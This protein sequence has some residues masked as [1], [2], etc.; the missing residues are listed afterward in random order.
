MTRIQSRN[1]STNVSGSTSIVTILM[2]LDCAL[3]GISWS[4]WWLANTDADLFLAQLYSSTVAAVD[5]TTNDLPNLIGEVRGAMKVGAAFGNQLESIGFFQP[6]FG[7][8]IARN[9]RLNLAL[10]SSSASVTIRAVLT[11]AAEV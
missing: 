6:C 3:L 9:T 8:F 10:L 1:L 2:P 11:L 4:G 7:L 5:Q